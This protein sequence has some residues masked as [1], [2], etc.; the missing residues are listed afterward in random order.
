[1]NITEIRRRALVRPTTPPAESDASDEITSPALESAP[2]RLAPWLGE[3]C[4]LHQV[5]V[6][7]LNGAG[8]VVL[9]PQHEPAFCTTVK[10][11]PGC[12][13]DCG[14]SGHAVPRSSSLHLFHCPYHLSNI[15]W[16]VRPSGNEAWTVIVGRTLATQEQMTSCL[17]VIEESDSLGD[18][19]LA[20]LGSIPWQAEPQLAA[21]TRFLQA[22]LE[23]IL[24]PETPRAPAAKS[25]VRRPTGRKSQRG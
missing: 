1:M 24:T 13:A 11:S 2:Q 3:F 22:S 14:R 6:Q 23:L 5:C 18:E 4:R 16:T 25:E 8:E 15:A 21:V 17:S 7:I 20:A 10:C 19:A 9:G 12:P